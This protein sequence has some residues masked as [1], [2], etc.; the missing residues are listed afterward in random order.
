M[1]HAVIND[2]RDWIDIPLAEVDRLMLS[3]N[4]SFN[5]ILSLQNIR[6]GY[7][8]AKNEILSLKTSLHEAELRMALAKRNAATASSDNGAM[9]EELV[10]TQKCLVDC[11]SE[12]RVLE[13][14]TCSYKLQLA[15]L[16][17]QVDDQKMEI[18][19]LNG[20]LGVKKL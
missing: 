9:K 1:L 5:A 11:Q 20:L 17:E 8:R 16:Q 19:A 18:I 13:A 6:L 3:V 14:K 15:S 10:S 7:V 2:V 12:Y 4:L